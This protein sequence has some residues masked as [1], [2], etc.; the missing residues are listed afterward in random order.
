MTL[1]MAAAGLVPPTRL[2]ASPSSPIFWPVSRSRR[3]SSR[4]LDAHTF[5]GRPLSPTANHSRPTLP[6]PP[7][8]PTARDLLAAGGFF[9][10]RLRVAVVRHATRGV[11]YHYCRHGWRRRHCEARA[12]GRQREMDEREVRRVGRGRCKSSLDPHTRSPVLTCPPLAV[13]PVPV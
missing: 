9:P 10:R 4:C 11:R 1:E 7:P 6:A 3:A 8:P 2:C 12:G 5:S 13:L